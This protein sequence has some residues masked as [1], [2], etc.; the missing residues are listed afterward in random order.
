MLDSAGPVCDVVDPSALPPEELKRLYEREHARAEAAEAEITAL[1]GRLGEAEARA[2][3]WKLESI[4]ARGEL[5]QLRGV[6]E[7][8]REKLAAARAE[9]KELGRSQSARNLRKLEKKLARLQG[10]LNAAGIDSGPHTIVGMRKEISRLKAVIAQQAEELKELK[11]ENERLRS[12]RATHEKARFGSTSEK[13]SRKGSGSGSS[14]KRG[15]QADKPGHGR[16][17]RPDMER[18]PEDHD[19]PEAERVCSCCGLPYVKN[20]S[21]ESEVIEIEVKAHVRIINRNRWRRSCS[22][23]SAPK[24]VVAPP[25]PRL[26]PHTL[27]GI[28]FWVCFLLERYA[29][30]RPL[31]RVA[32]WMREQGLPVSAGTL[33]DSIHRLIPLFEPLSQAILAQLNTATMLHGDETG[34]RVQSL[35]AIRGTSR[36]WLWGAVSRDAVWFHIDARRSAEAAGKLFANIGAGT[37]LVCDAYAAY[38]KLARSLAGGLILAWCWAH[39]RRKFIQ[40][41]AGHDALEA[42]EDRWLKRIGRIYHLNAV[43]LKHYDPELGMDQQSRRFGVVHRQLKRALDK[44]FATA[45]RE[46]AGRAGSDRRGKPLRSLLRHRD[47]LCVFVDR[48]DVPM[49]NNLMERILRDPVIERKLSFG[50][51]SLE[52]ARYSAMMYGIF[53]TLRMNGI[54]V[55]KW[56]DDWLSACAGNGGQPPEDLSPWLPWSMDEDR[57]RH[58]KATR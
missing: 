20:G 25:V 14:R 58:L 44:L 8:N 7:S 34:W 49:D 52:G 33:G 21:H 55:R 31:N 19:P 57:R 28:S 48:P 6:F 38:K 24:E 32:A 56:L 50:S 18:K 22:C 41:A 36:A 37:I 46:L 43:R 11:A 26:F 54:D 13:K 2:N 5:N 42:W 27:F 12:A 51:D 1:K 10:L 16:T 35:K 17:P 29:F 4:R 39:L 23:A 3:D 53:E 30:H 40:A 45:E 15:Q 9:L 47:G